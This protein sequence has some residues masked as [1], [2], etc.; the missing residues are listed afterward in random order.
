M[1]SFEEVVRGRRSIGKVKED[2]VPRKLVEK[3]IE[4]A[5]WAPNH[6]RTEP[7]RFIVMTGEGR[8]VLGEAYAAIA[9]AGWGEL[10]EE[11]RAARRQAEV[12]KALRAPVVIAAVCSPSDDARALPQEEL[13]AAHAA[14][15]NL[16]LAAHDNGL[17]AVWRTGAPAYHPVMKQAFKLEDRETVVGFVYVGYPDMPQPAAARTPA[18]EKT[19]WLEG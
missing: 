3:L 12:A 15:Q 10:A 9:S 19:I 17:G 14:V 4:A 18:A 5:V 11:E 8:K 7:W 2:P 13:A 6:F 1:A 16:L